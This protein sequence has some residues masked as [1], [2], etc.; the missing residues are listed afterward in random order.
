MFGT[1]GVLSIDL[2]RNSDMSMGFHL[3]LIIFS[4][5][6][7]SIYSEE[8]ERYRNNDTIISKFY[9]DAYKSYWRNILN[10]KYKKISMSKSYLDQAELDHTIISS[11][12]KNGQFT[13]KP[14]YFERLKNSEKK[15][16]FLISADIIN[17]RGLPIK[18]E[19]GCHMVTRR[20][21][22]LHFL[23]YIGDCISFPHPKR[24]DH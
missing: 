2:K 3:I 23:S 19:T 1:V 17:H 24:H 12:I 6:S 21:S 13:I 8:M 9:V 7:F 16:R 11:H 4:M 20:K 18:K 22:K 14:V 15:E 10:K 5:S